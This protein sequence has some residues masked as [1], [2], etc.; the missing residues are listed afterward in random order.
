MVSD[1]PPAKR[2]RAGP[3]SEGTTGADGADAR[4]LAPAPARRDLY[5]DTINR[6]LLDFDFEKVCSVSLSNVNIYACLVCGKMFQ[7]R[8]RRTHAYFHAINEDHRVFMQL[9]SARVFVLPDNYEVHDPSLSDIQHLLQLPYTEKQIAQLDAPDAP[10]ALDLHARPYLPGFVGLNNIAKNDAMNVVIQA[11]AHVPPLR[12]Y[13]IRG[14]RTRAEAARGVADP[15]AQSTELV[16]RFATLVRKLWNGR[17][18]KGQVSPHEFLQE[19]AN[20]SQQ[21]FRLTEQADPVAFLGWLLN[22]LHF[23]LVGGA[24][25]RRRPSIITECFQGD[26]RMDSQQ[27]IVR[28]GLEDEY[29]ADKLD[30]DGR[31]AGGQEDERGNAKFNIDKGTSSAAP[32]T[33]EIKVTHSPFLLL[34]IDLPPPP[35]FQDVVAQNII[36][37]VP[38]AQVLAKYDGVSFQ[39]AAG[40]IRRY[41]LTRLPPYLIL[42]FRRFT[43]N[44]FVEER[45]PTIINFPTHGLDVSDCVTSDVRAT[46]PTAYNLLAN[47]THE[48]TPGTVRDNSTWRAQVHTR[49]DGE[50]VGRRAPVPDG[51]QE[52]AEGAQEAAEERWFQMQDLIVEDVNPQMLFLGESCIQIWERKDTAQQV[53]RAA[54]C[55]RVAPVRRRT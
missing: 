54:D 44:R 31:R 1:A 48:V 15:F 14:G 24:A 12:N 41:H 47:I 7:G 38:L 52:T 51:A 50:P 30:H 49:R 19:V 34:A 6:S 29:V 3:G 28:S 17:A 40:S 46:V 33:A 43:K 16:R 4:A 10:P 26:V 2:A 27:V 36:P 8:G 25:A 13:L 11:L 23:D 39:E 22:Q 53:E 32:L 20:A 9:E 37:Q 21:R 35:V 45:N 42:H 18:F 5:L 55:L